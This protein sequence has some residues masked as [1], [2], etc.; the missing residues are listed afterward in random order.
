MKI[1]V[2]YSGELGKKVIQNLINSGKFLRVLRRALQ[3]LQA[4]QEVIR[5]PDC[6]NS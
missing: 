5:K 3:P 2:L 4:G 6:G 1:L